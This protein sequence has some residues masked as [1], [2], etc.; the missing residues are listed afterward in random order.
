MANSRSRVAPGCGGRTI[1]PRCFRR[2]I[3]TVALLLALVTPAAAQDFDAGWEAYVRGD[4]DDALR[5][6]RVWADQGDADAQYSLGVMYDLGQGVAQDDAE[7]VKWYRA[8]A[9]QGVAD[10]DI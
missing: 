2:L 10:L 4:Y 8:A 3:P 9:E 5:V 7:A 6:F 1:A